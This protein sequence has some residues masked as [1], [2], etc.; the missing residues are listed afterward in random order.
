MARKARRLT[1]AGREALAMYCFISPWLIGFLLFILGPLAASLVLSFFRWEVIVPPVFV[2]LRNWA[3]V[4]TADPTVWHSLK[5]T[6]IYTVGTVGL[7]IIISLCLAQLT[8]QKLPGMVVFRAAIM[9]PYA[10]SGV[11]AGLVWRWICNG[12]FGLV[13]YLLS[14][15]GIK[16]PNWL[17]STTWSLPALIGLSLWGIGGTVNVFLA[18]LQNVPKELYDAVEIDGA[19]GW[20]KWWY[21]TRPMLSPVIFFQTIM[22]II[23]SFQAFANAYIVT[24]GGPAKSTLLFGLLIYQKAFTEYK[25]G[26][27]A[28]LA[29]LLFLV[30]LGLALVLF[31]SSS[32]WV[33]YGGE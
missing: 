29:W 12:D 28:A 3:E 5:V 15:I 31:R 32:R 2:G 23:I 16:G 22:G 24:A 1:L 11:A 19:N 30:V 33:Y 7:S 17:F 20:K 10:V 14:R 25:M 21:V 4:L 6:S 27:A 26:Y 9:L 18:G 8:F 13:N